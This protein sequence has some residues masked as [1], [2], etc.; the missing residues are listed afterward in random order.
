MK[1]C[2]FLCN[3]MSPFSRKKVYGGERQ[4]IPQRS[5]GCLL[6]MT[7]VSPDCRSREC[8]SVA[9]FEAPWA[10]AARKRP[11]G[12]HHQV[13]RGRQ[14]K[15]H[16]NSSSRDSR[17]IRSGRDTGTLYRVRSKAAAYRM[18]RTSGKDCCN[19]LT[20]STGNTGR[21]EGKKGSPVIQSSPGYRG[22]R[23]DRRGYR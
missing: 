7:Y 5:G 11:S 21:M 12:V 19:V 2:L 9:H 14:N 1:K 8:A 20:G 16:T 10:T 4:D 18:R 17:S 15:R 3:S 13:R 23:H 22:A 6:V